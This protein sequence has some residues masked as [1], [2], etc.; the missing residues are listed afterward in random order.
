MYLNIANLPSHK[1]LLQYS[2]SAL[3]RG[4]WKAWLCDWWIEWFSIRPHVSYG[5]V[6]TCLPHTAML[7]I[8]LPMPVFSLLVLSTWCFYVTLHKGAR[9]TTLLP[10]TRLCLQSLHLAFLESE[11]AR[12]RLTYTANKFTHHRLQ[13]REAS[14]EGN[15]SWSPVCFELHIEVACLAMWCPQSL[16]T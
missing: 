3:Q 11:N 16:C 14:G 6:C 9:D 10:L 1:F 7:S 15:G 4:K 8:F 5:P 2:W 12:T 13:K